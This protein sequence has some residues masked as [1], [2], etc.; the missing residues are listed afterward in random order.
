ML[1]K[2][3]FIILKNSEKMIVGMLFNNDIK[4]IKSNDLTFSNGNKCNCVDY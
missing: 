4:K 1:T 3:I 2:K